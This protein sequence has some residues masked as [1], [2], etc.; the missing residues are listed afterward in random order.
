[1]AGIDCAVVV[2]DKGP[3]AWLGC[4]ASGALGLA[5]SAC[6]PLGASDEHGSGDP[7][8]EAADEPDVPGPSLLVAAVTGQGLQLM[9]IDDGGSV[10]TYGPVI[11]SVGRA[12]QLRWNAARSRGALLL[13]QDDASRVYGIDGETLTLLSEGLAPVRKIELSDR[14]HMVALHHEDWTVSFVDQS[15]T[16][17]FE[18]PPQ[19][20]SGSTALFLSDDERWVAW[21]VGEQLSEYSLQRYDFA[22][23]TDAPLPVDVHSGGLVS[24]FASSILLRSSTAIVWADL[25]GQPLEID[26]Q[27]SVAAQWQRRYFFEGGR[28]GQVRDREVVDLGPQEIGDG[29]VHAYLPGAYAIVESTDGL[30]QLAPDGTAL[31]TFSPSPDYSFQL[32]ATHLDPTAPVVLIQ[33]VETPNAPGGAGGVHVLWLPGA[34]RV[35]ELGYSEELPDARFT[36][37]G[38]LIRHHADGSLTRV[39]PRANEIEKSIDVGDATIE[40]LSWP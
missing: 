29:N 19:S 36:A 17:V 40:Q 13:G 20:D 35:H 25:E 34:Q 6:G 16:V 28:A 11:P 30:R 2:D 15:G 10:E 3:M 14:G 22:L 39:D 32:K 26:G 21:L 27:P 1:M 23:G 33:Q 9:A 24:P 8:W 12:R 38:T 18:L 7:V 4:V 31:G 37:G 5:M